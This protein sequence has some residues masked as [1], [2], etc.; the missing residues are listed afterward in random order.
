MRGPIFAR[1]HDN[2][3]TESRRDTCLQVSAL[4]RPHQLLVPCAGC[5]GGPVWTSNYMTDDQRHQ[6][7]PTLIFPGSCTAFIPEC[8]PYY[9][10]EAREFECQLDAS[11]WQ[12]GELL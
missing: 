8:S 9:M 7:D 3:M 11:G 4:A 5:V 2:V 6:D 12:W 10:G 1:R